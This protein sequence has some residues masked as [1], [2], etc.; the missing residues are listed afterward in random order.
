M[1]ARVLGVTAAATAAG[2]RMNVSGST[3]TSTARAPQSSTT[4]A[5]AGNVYAGTMTSSPGP[6]SSA[7]TARWSAAVP[8]ETA[9]ACAVPTA[10]GE[11]SLELRHLR[12]H[13]ELTAL[14][15]LCDRG[16]LRVADVGPREPDR[17][18]VTRSGAPSVLAVP[19]DRP[20]EALVELDLGLEAEQLAGLLDVRDPQ[21]DVRVVE[22]LEDD[23]ARA[24][25]RGA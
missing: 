9:A 14:E 22:R 13:R 23:V 20:V 12:A 1:T 2:S 4:F 5:V 6:I 25:G 21:L 17:A 7:S 10:A 3:S 16:E 11:R 24:P 19:R 15:H 8:D 18:R